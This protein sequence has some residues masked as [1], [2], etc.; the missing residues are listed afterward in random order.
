MLVAG[1][2]RGE[3]GERE[4]LIV[5]W[6]APLGGM[7]IIACGPFQF[8]PLISLAT[9]GMLLRRIALERRAAPVFQRY[10]DE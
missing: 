9:L 5:L 4:W 1:C 7:L 10:A 2:E 3:R 6:I 8:M